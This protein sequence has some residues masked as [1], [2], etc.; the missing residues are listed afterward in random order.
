MRQRSRIA[1]GRVRVRQ[2]AGRRRSLPDALIIGAQR[3]GTSSL[4]KYLGMHPDVV[5]PLRKETQYFSRYYSRGAN[6]YRAHFPVEAM[7]R[8][9]KARR[10]TGVLTFEATPDYLLD[11][12]S[13]DRAAALL[14]NARVIVLVRDPVDRAY[15]HYH[16]MR[17]LGFESLPFE[18]A[19]AVE[20]QR[21]TTDL[22]LLASNPNHQANQLLRYSYL[23]RGHYAEQ[24]T[25]WAS[26]YPNE[27]ILIVHSAELFAKPEDVFEE[28]L[29]FLGLRSWAPKQF[30]NFSARDGDRQTPMDPSTRNRLIQ[31]FDPHNRRLF[32]AIGRE[33]PW[34]RAG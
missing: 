9:R 1:R 8:T 33:L 12:R 29:S 31:H 24:L 27:R 10:S 17:R 13:A 7:K 34:G 28:I 11:P 5:P 22:R 15:S 25:R 2:V 23:M 3:C 16:H 30:R 20:H 4:Y 21:I 18:R 32:D 19:I 6:W 26:R 14:P